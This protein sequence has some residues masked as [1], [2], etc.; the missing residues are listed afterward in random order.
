MWE[1]TILTFQESS[2]S[3]IAMIKK[4]CEDGKHWTIVSDGG[5]VNRGW[6]AMHCSLPI[7]WFEKKLVV[8]HE[9]M[10]KDVMRRDRTIKKG[11]Y[12]GSSGGMEPEGLRRALRYLHEKGILTLASDIV[13]DKDSSATK[14]VEE[15]K[16]CKHLTLRYDPG[17]VSKS[18][19]NQLLK[20]FGE[21]NQLRAD[22]YHSTPVSPW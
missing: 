13:M 20:L 1:K 18:L 9:V 5:W 10:S 19:V 4:E 8:W 3:V 12:E 21:Q 7:C 22:P 16:I 2:D 15:L 17:H 6:T 14:T 11:N